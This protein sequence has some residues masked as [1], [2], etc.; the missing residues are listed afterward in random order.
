MPKLDSSRETCILPVTM[1]S[2]APLSAPVM[3]GELMS[4]I[5]IMPVGVSSVEWLAI[6]RR[7]K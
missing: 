3:P 6:T 5:T 4:G 2:P 1:R 7:R